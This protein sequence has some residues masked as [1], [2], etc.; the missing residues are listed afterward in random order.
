MKKMDNKL[1]YLPIEKP[2][3]FKKEKS[4]IFT[5]I[6]IIL[7]MGAIGST[8]FFGAKYYSKYIDKVE[9]DSYLRGLTESSI[10]LQELL[11]KNAENC[12][13]IPVKIDEDTTYHLIATECLQN[14]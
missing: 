7:V 3:K 11:M 2:L 1:N 5:I 10:Y 13:P 14:E 9:S 8:S 12:N 6:L 4:K